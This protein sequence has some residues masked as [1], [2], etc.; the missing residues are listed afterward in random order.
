[1]LNKLKGSKFFSRKFLL[2]LLGNIIG[3]VSLIASEGEGDVQII[4][5]IILIIVSTCT[6]IMQEAKVDA[7]SVQTKVLISAEQIKQLLDELKNNDDPLISKSNDMNEE[8]K[9]ES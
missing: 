3:I 2:S 5:S 7:L 1:M 8:V 9:K 6:Y 4:A